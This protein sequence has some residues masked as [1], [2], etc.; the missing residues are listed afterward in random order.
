MGLS[1]T[2]NFP[3]AG[4]PAASGAQ[5]ILLQSTPI[6]LSDIFGGRNV[7]PVGSSFVIQ[8]IVKI[9]SDVYD[10]KLLRR[11]DRWFSPKE[12]RGTFQRLDF[13]GLPWSGEGDTGL[14][15]TSPHS[16]THYN[17]WTV[18]L[19]PTKQAQFGAE[20]IV[21]QCNFFAASTVVTFPP[22]NIPTPGF[23]VG[24]PDK[25]QFRTVQGVAAPAL[26]DREY[27]PYYGGL[28]LF[29]YPGVAG[30]RVEFDF[31][32][33]NTVYDDSSEWESPTCSLT[34]N[35]C[36]AIRQEFIDANPGRLFD[37][38][39]DCLAAGGRCPEGVFYCDDGTTLPLWDFG[40]VGGP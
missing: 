30:I 15:R 3:N 1:F 10:P 14:I 36:A 37:N 23:G 18:G 17:H 8:E 29:F 5:G 33:I 38:L 9:V 2:Y 4:T 22:A 32:I 31:S 20:G 6:M 19:D 34:T 25:V 16:M 13:S 12:Y 26:Q 7:F 40:V 28:G 24:D 39:Q 11:E 35:N 21:N 27:F